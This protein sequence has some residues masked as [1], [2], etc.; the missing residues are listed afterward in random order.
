MRL[1]GALALTASLGAP[2]AAAPSAD[3]WI[4]APHPDPSAWK[5]ILQTAE[6]FCDRETPPGTWPFDPRVATSADPA[7]RKVFIHYFPPYPLSFTN[8]PA[9]EDVYS[10]DYLRREG[11]HGKYFDA[12]GLVRDRPLPVGPWASP[13]WI[14]INYAIEI[15]RAQRMGAAGFA[16]D[17][18][19][20][21]SGRGA[22]QLSLMLD[23]AA[24]VAPQFRI[25]PEPDANILKSASAADLESV[26]DR[27]WSH[28]ASLH[29]PDGRLLVAPFAPDL[30]PAA[31]WQSLVGDMRA[32]NEPIAF[33]PVLL[34]VQ[35]FAKSFAPFSYGES[36][37]GDRDLLS[38]DVLPEL[39][40]AGSL[41]RNGIWMAPVAPQDAR[42]NQHVL[43]EARNT[44]YYRRAWMDAIQDG[45][46][47]VQLITWNDY[48]ESTHV[49]P[50]VFTQFVYYDLGAFYA[51][52]FVSGSMPRITRDALY[53]TYRREIF[54]PSRLTLPADSPFKPMGKT[55]VGNDIEMLAFLTQPAT[56]QIDIDGAVVEK[57]GAAGLVELRIPAR[58]GTPV[59]RI[60]RNRHPIIET[61]GQWRIVAQEPAAD[62]VYAGGSS[63][64]AIVAMPV[65][66]TSP[67]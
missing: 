56:L 7:A 67:Q 54:V 1:A 59:F 19:D 41:S 27:V 15:L 61:V 18:V 42:P 50:S 36:T 26:L 58:V 57:G 4:N 55:P 62:P 34:D 52:W 53:Y 11:E 40:R 31:F 14:Q 22:A 30:E 51:R 12:G 37:W 35:S 17:I 10:T 8:R 33:L 45:S 2:L 3:P 47:Y 39:Q 32:R 24:A 60:V 65:G 16:F 23:T 66:M 28:P 9:P 20:V 21:G 5:Q 49:E 43:W 29:L 64:R 63:T 44:Q 13:Y 48:S 38:P 25:V 46:R 6:D